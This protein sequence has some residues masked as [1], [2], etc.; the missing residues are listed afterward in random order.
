MLKILWKME[1]LPLSTIFYH[2]MLD[3]YVKIGIRFSLRDKRLFKITE[4]EITRVDCICFH[5]E[6]RKYISVTSSYLDLWYGIFS[7]PVRI[8]K[9][10]CCSA[11]GVA[12]DIGVK[13][14]VKDFFMWWAGL[15]RSGKRYLENEIFSQYG[16]VREFCWWLGK[17]RKDLKNQGKVREFCCWPGKFRKDSENQ[18]KVREIKNKWLW[19]TVLRKFIYSVQEGKGCTFSWDSLSPSPSSL[20]ATLKEKNL[21]PYGANSFL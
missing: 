16:K 5:W 1:F 12:S 21:L 11:L 2:L 10:D 6:I 14:S 13:Q 9:K 8:Y 15:P 20:G 18:G 3:F 17:F 19:Q 7:S 4:V